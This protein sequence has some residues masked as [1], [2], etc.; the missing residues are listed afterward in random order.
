M[1]VTKVVGRN[2]LQEETFTWFTVS[3]HSITEG[4]DVSEGSHLPS[5]VRIEKWLIL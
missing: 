5:M 2:N 3:K 1:A 4:K